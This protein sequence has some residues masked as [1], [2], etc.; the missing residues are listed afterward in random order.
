MRRAFVLLAVWIGLVSFAGAQ[1]LPELA[2]PKNYQL[3]F[4]PDFTSDKFAGDETIQIEVKKPTSEIVLNSAEIEFHEVSIASGGTTQTAH[5]SIDKDKEMATLTVG[6]PLPA[7]PAT[8]HIQY[9]GILN[10]ELRGFYLGKDKEGRKYA[11]TQFEATDARRA[12][13]SFDEPAY[14][15]TFDITVVADKGLSAISNGKVV[16]DEAGPSADKHSVKFATTAKMS[17]YLVALAVG[18]FEYIEGSA[19][20]IPIRVWGPPGSKQYAGFALD[21]AE[22]CMKYYNQYFGIKYPFEKLDMIGLPDFAAG[23]MENTGFITYREVILLLD[24]KTASVGLKKEVAVVIAH[25]MAHQWFGDLVTMQWWDDIWLNEGFATWMESKAVGVLKPEWHMDLDDVEDTNRALNVDALKHTRPIHQAAETPAQIQELFDGIAYGKTAAVLRMLEAYLGPETFRA[26]VDEYLKRHEYGNATAGDF[27]KTLTTVSKKPV[28]QVMPTFVTQPGAPMVSVQTQCSGGA[29][30]VALAQKRYF[31]DRSLFNTGNDELWQVP[32]CMKEGAENGQ[33]PLKC[34]LLTKKQEDFQLPGCGPWVVVNAGAHGYYH[35][36]YSAN[37][38]RALS[39]ALEKQLTPAERIVLLND[40]WAAMRVG[41]ARIGDYLALAEGLQADRTRAVLEQLTGQ[42]D[43]ISDHLVNDQDR[44]GYEHWVRQLL[45][46]AANDLGW[47]SKPGDSDETKELRARVLY[48]LGYAG[49]DPEA[50]AAARKLTEQGLENPSSVDH[51]LAF[52]AF[53]LAAMSGDAA[54]YD[55]IAEKL[56]SKDTTPEEYYLYFGALA[57]FSDPKLLERTLELAVSP[58]VR[59][60]D[61]L[62]LISAVMQNPAGT[63]LAWDFVRA[64]WTDIEKVGGGFTSSEVVA[65][66]GAF[67]DARLRDEVEEF[68]TTHK[69]PTAERTL[70]QSVEHMNYCVDLKAQQS[71]QL[72]SWLEVHGG[73][74]GR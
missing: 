21:I 16:S 46:P 4:T 57:R 64:H 12:F 49:K 74:A 47:N 42:L 72:S 43:Y 27:W 39:R 9:T 35:S 45:G 23:A 11:V 56:K 14:K 5:V 30:T 1:R 25:E 58:A 40:S 48:A 18:N 38:M 33:A 26:G 32:V 61:S 55:R 59:S 8:V 52:T 24:D 36:G 44:A 60:Q 65:A 34:V 20:G 22:Q 66:T 3:T 31:Y 50:L 62:G 69:V 70:K 15:A 17:S 29:S 7:G 71:P 63:T 6:K 19:D 54:L 68:F 67:C 13:P 28:D 73:A 41:Q 2:S 53:S 37:A 51:T 10:S